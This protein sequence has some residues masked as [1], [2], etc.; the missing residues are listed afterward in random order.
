MLIDGTTRCPHCDTRFKVAALQLQA[1]FGRVRCGN[2]LQAFD[3]IPNFIADEAS[4]QLEIPQ[5]VLAPTPQRV[6]KAPTIRTPAYAGNRTD[7]NAIPNFTQAT[8][9]AALFVATGAFANFLEEDEPQPVKHRWLLGLACLLLLTALLGQLGYVYR[10]QIAARM[11]ASKP[12]LT[13]ACEWLECSLSLPQNA[14]LISIE[15]SSLEAETENN[16]R[17][18]LSVLI[19]SRSSYALALPNLEVTLNDNQDQPLARRIF[20]PNE[21]L[22]SPQNSNEG[23]P[24]N[25][26][27][28]LRLMLELDNLTPSGYRLALVYPTS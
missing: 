26:E 11:P 7:K 16:A 22:R 14:E 5:L 27:T 21:Y 2:C 12:L 8:K 19:R 6:A 18:K 28:T 24:A 13:A 25:Q 9:D 17:I 10:A 20:T 15:S 4:P 1:Q 3:A 23:L